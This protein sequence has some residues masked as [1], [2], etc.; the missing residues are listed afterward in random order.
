MLVPPGARLGLVLVACVEKLG[1]GLLVRHYALDAWLHAPRLQAGQDEVELLSP[2]R[3]L[4]CSYHGLVP[5][6]GCVHRH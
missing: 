3:I 6:R 2:A 1:L 5:V 4:S